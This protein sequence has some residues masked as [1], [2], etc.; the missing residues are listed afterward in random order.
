MVKANGLTFKEIDVDKII[1]NPLN[2][3]IDL[4]PGMP[5]YE[6]LRV[7]IE[8]F[9][10][11]EPIVVNKEKDGSYMIISGHQRLQVMKDLAKAKNEEIT[12]V[13]VIVKEYDKQRRDALT[14]ALNKITGLWDN[15]KLT[16]LFNDM[17]ESMRQFTGFEDFEIENLIA[18]ISEMEEEVEEESEHKSVR[19]EEKWEIII[20]CKSEKDLNEKFDKL[21]NEGYECRISTL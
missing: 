14:I 9:D 6:K 18:V 4:K 11:S 8:E 2:P 21:K 19:Y 20:S 3:R 10:Y 13:S 15:E 5:M 16:V 1:P 12:T 7:S 17:D